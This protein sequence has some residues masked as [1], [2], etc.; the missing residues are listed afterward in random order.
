[1]AE[2]GLSEEG[3]SEQ[4]PGHMK[5]QEDTPSGRTLTLKS[6]K[7]GGEGRSGMLVGLPV[8]QSGESRA[9]YQ[10][11]QQQAEGSGELRGHSAFGSRPFRA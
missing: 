8:R 1:M 9:L 3:A 2:E 6:P 7:G 4:R 11:S 10:V 5:I